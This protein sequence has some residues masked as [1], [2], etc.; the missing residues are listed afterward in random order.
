MAGGKK[1]F[2]SRRSLV[3]LGKLSAEGQLILHD[4]AL[5]RPAL[6]TPSYSNDQLEALR[7][8]FDLFEIG[9]AKEKRAE[10]T[11]LMTKEVTMKEAWFRKLIAELRR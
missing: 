8:A 3:I 10:L 2:N 7:L 1:C 5:G 11:A 9:R 6:A 4:C